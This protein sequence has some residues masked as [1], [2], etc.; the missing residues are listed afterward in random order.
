MS[1]PTIDI[2]QENLRRREPSMLATRRP[3]GTRRGAV[4]GS[5]AKIWAKI[6]A[7]EL[8]SH[9]ITRW[10]YRIECHGVQDSV[11]LESF[12]RVTGDAICSP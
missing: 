8:L 5:R 2:S 11:R 12:E 3:T 1:P 7:G 4:I 9:F 10:W 6:S